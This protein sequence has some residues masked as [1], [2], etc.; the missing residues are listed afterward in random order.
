MDRLD[1]LCVEDNEDFQYFIDRAFKK[2]ELNLNYEIVE[3]GKAAIESLKS[4]KSTKPPK[5]VFLDI[6]LPDTDGFEVLKTIKNDS[7]L[8]HIPVIMLSTSEHHKDINTAYSYGANAYITKPNSMK[9]II[10]VMNDSSKF[11]I[12]HNYPVY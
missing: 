10:E 9:K 5:M 11:W 2:S 7:Y 1:V 12:K 4:T 8:K 6:N 3:T